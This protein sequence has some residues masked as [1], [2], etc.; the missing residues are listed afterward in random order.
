M[1]VERIL[2]E[3]RGERKRQGRLLRKLNAWDD[4]VGDTT[5]IYEAHRA[6]RAS[7]IKDVEC[8][9]VKYDRLITRYWG[10]SD[11]CELRAEQ[12]A[13]TAGQILEDKEE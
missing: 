12:A 3:L 6:A 2:T 9:M 4:Y 5:V 8:A 7:L 11:G 13:I 10:F 1:K